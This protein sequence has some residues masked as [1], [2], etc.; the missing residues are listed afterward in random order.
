MWP[1]PGGGIIRPLPF[2]LLTFNKGL[3]IN[4]V[5]IEYTILYSLLSLF[6]LILNPD[7]FDS[8]VL[9]ADLPSAGEPPRGGHAG[10]LPGAAGGQEEGLPQLHHE[11]DQRP[12][13]R[14]PR[15]HARRVRGRGGGDI[16]CIHIEV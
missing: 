1:A 10:D 3:S 4:D 6:F 5:I 12:A 7:T 15:H 16:N 11:P 8:V 13:A 14:H 9:C 2:Q